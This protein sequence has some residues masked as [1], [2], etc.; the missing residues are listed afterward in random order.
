MS[1]SLVAVGAERSGHAVV[2]GASIAGCLTARVL[3]ERFARLTVLQR[4]EVSQEPV[5]RRG[6]PQENHVHLLLQ[7]EKY[8]LEELFP[9][10]LAE[11]ERP[12]SLRWQ[13]WHG[14]RLVEAA[15]GNQDVLV[16]LLRVTNLIEDGG[17]LYKPS[18]IMRVMAASLKQ[19]LSI[20]EGGAS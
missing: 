14:E 2:I 13:H 6:G 1:N 8:I 17:S 10:V 11:M 20:P 4:N 15:A 18:M 5:P 19:R 16:A 3:S 9:G 12:F 7:R